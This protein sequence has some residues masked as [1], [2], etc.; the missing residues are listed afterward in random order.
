MFLSTLKA[1]VAGHMDKGIE[2]AILA[3]ERNK[4]TV[5]LVHNW[6][7]HAT[8]TRSSGIGLVELE[9]GLPIGYLGMG[10][11]YASR[12][13]VMSWDL[14]DAVV[15]FYDHNCASCSDRTPVSLP[16]ISQL[17]E[18][19]DH[20]VE[21]RLSE[22]QAAA[23]QARLAREQRDARRSALRATVGTVPSTIVD[24]IEDLDTRRNAEAALALV[25]TVEIAPESFTPEIVDYLYETIASNEEWIL[26][27][28]LRILSALDQGTVRL[29]KAAIMVLSRRLND[30]AGDILVTSPHPFEPGDA[31]AMY[32]CAVELARPRRSAMSRR[33]SVLK[34]QL[35]L[36]VFR[37][38]PNETKA[39]IRQSLNSR[40]DADIHRAA[41][42]I[43]SLASEY[44]PFATQYARDIVA[45]VCRIDTLVDD[46]DDEHHDDLLLDRLEICCGHLMREAPEDTV[47][48]IRNYAESASDEGLVRLVQACDSA[49]SGR[50]TTR[51]PVDENQATPALHFLLDLAAT[52]KQFQVL[53]AIS[54]IFR[55]HKTPIAITGRSF[56]LLLGSA[57]VLIERIE[58]IKRPEILPDTFYNNLEFEN[59]RSSLANIVEG[60]LAWLIAATQNS[61]DHARSYIAF[62]KALPEGREALHGRM[63]EA[64][65]PLLDRVDLMA[66]FLPEFYSSLL[67]ASAMM[68][69]Y[70][71]R[72]L[73]NISLRA[74]NNLPELVFEAAAA[75]LTDRYIVVHQRAFTAVERGSFP[76]SYKESN[77]SAIANLIVTYCLP[78]ATTI[79]NR[80]SFLLDCIA[81]YCGTSPKS[82]ASSPFAELLID[83]LLIAEPRNVARQ[84]RE[85]QQGLNENP[86]FVDILS[87]ITQNEDAIHYEN[88]DIRKA[89]SMLPAMSLK[90]AADRIFEVARKL[91]PDAQGVSLLLECLTRIGALDKAEIIAQM[92]HDRIPDTVRDAPQR[93]HA[94][95]RVL[96]IKLERMV[97]AGDFQ[98]NQALKSELLKIQTSM[99]ERAA[100]D[101]QEPPFPSHHFSP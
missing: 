51:Q 57:A 65:A 59:A 37:D 66:I 90:A 85:I 34:P 67:G 78:D 39:A 17:V 26:D 3:G 93:D 33:D 101:Q 19:R 87:K 27:C 100:R 73:E 38:Q 52:S 95:L 4:A 8:I 92:V 14:R 6:C 97:E 58:E 86:R 61:T 29:T 62:M 2:R 50:R 88:D 28:A 43:D 23:T 15:Q 70:A 69:A 98:S 16:N 83:K 99:N 7:A 56:D 13:G 77:R 68:R 89:F 96:S 25:K 24:Q 22:G 44:S 60:I 36:K 80:D 46:H 9:T 84:L 20:A 10:C 42:A 91:P 55:S 76:P 11:P 94:R 79:H 72:T 53:G 74:R 49:L 32:R 35:L 82:L 41:R 30:V 63:I 75:L 71:V 5:A 40:V 21:A 45:L 64:A 47:K 18:E 31:T 48:L 12:A 1:R 81:Y 54:Q